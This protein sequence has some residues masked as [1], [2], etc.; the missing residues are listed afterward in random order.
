VTLFV[1]RQGATSGTNPPLPGNEGLTFAIWG[2]WK[3]GAL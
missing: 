2:A 1:S 3:K